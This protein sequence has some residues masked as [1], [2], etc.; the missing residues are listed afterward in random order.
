MIEQLMCTFESDFKEFDKVEVPLHDL[1]FLARCGLV[2]RDGSNLK[3]T[4]RG[5][6]FTRNIA[7]SFNPYFNRQSER[8]AKAA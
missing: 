3:I 1:A 4:K 5:R 6:V 2:E 7:A 8:H